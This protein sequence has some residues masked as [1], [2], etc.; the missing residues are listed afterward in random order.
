MSVNTFG[1]LLGNLWGAGGA[2]WG[3]ADGQSVQGLYTPIG[4][5][6]LAERHGQSSRRQRFAAEM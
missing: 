4:V 3:G 2:G 6:Y 5:S 1:T